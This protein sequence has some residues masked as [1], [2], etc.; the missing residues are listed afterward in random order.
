MKQVDRSKN[1]LYKKTG[2]TTLQRISL[3]KIA[4]M[5]TDIVVDS[6]VI[7]AL[8]TPEQYSLGFQE[9]IRI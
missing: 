6:S 2:V 5:L 4:S 3:G 9:I 1:E 7:A 8:V